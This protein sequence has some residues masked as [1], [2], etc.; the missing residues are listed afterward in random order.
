M[1][2]H[3]YIYIYVYTYTHIYI[4][5]ERERYIICVYIYVYIYIYIY[6]YRSAFTRPGLDNT[7]SDPGA[8][9]GSQSAARARSSDRARSAVVR[10]SDLQIVRMWAEL[11]ERRRFLVAYVCSAGVASV[12]RMTSSVSS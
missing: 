6:I 10:I 9:D 4:Y 12:L 7:S 3:V 11:T 5:R 2:V 1:C 8:F